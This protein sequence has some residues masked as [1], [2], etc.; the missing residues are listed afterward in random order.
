MKFILFLIDN[1]TH[2]LSRIKFVQT[3]QT[4]TS[5][6]VYKYNLLLHI[7]KHHFRCTSNLK[8]FWQNI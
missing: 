5:K 4:L 7:S 3:S 2:K 6:L 8:I 1:L